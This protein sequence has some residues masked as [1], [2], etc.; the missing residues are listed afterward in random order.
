MLV[1]FGPPFDT[2]VSCGHY[3]VIQCVAFL[4]TILKKVT[5]SR[6]KKVTKN[7]L[8]GAYLFC[9]SF[10]ASLEGCIVQLQHHETQQKS[11]WSSLLV[12]MGSP[13]KYSKELLQRQKVSPTSKTGHVK[14]VETMPTSQTESSTET[15]LAEFSLD[16]KLRHR[17]NTLRI[18]VFVT[19]PPFFPEKKQWP[20]NTPS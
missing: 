11:I 16:I 17:E 14:F 7:H 6:P 8:I 5:F 10:P 2:Q 18:F 19:F 4:S 13:G 9:M 20:K 15:L 1:V 12:W 3:Q